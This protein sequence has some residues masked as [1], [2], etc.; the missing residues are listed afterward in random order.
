MKNILNKTAAV[1]GAASG[2]GR[3][4]GVNLAREGCN[5]AIADIDE[6]GL[7]ETAALIGD[8]VK[9]STHVVDV[10]DRSQVFRFAEEAAAYHGGI[11][12][13]INNAGVALGDFLET[14]PLEDFEWLMGIN[15]WGVVYGTMAFLPIL[16][17]Q[18]EGH[19]VNISS[20]NGILPNPNNGPYCAAK[21]AVKGYT[22]A[23]AQEMHGTN[24]SVSCVHPGGIKTNIAR[25]TRFNRAMY[26]LTR[27]RAVSL[28]EDELFRTTADEAARAIISGIKN[29]RRRILI[30]NDARVI[31]LMTRLFPVTAVNVSG[32]FSRFI[33]R[34]YARK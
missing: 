31:D 33:V 12:I 24:I 1:T 23:L 20:I 6:S 27:D 7:K 5:L 34:S 29:N 19:I 26:S 28:Y 30:G 22:E 8:R 2:I 4:L 3:M 11:D 9:V 10:S 32:W 18:P 17:K 16:K 15:F 14:V 21:F 13:V 25:N